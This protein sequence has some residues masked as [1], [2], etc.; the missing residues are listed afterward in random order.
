MSPIWGRRHIGST[1]SNHE[2]FDF[3]V[4]DDDADYTY[5]NGVIWYLLKYI[6]VLKESKY[7]GPNSVL[8]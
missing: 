7:G 4:Y 8:S 2:S 3:V 6:L 5:R 1:L